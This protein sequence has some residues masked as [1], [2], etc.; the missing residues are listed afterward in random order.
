MNKLK[1]H[2]VNKICYDLSLFEQIVL[3]I[4]KIFSITGTIFSHSRSRAAAANFSQA[5]SN[6][7]PQKILTR[8]FLLDRIETQNLGKDQTLPAFPALAALRS[9][10]FW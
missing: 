7:L 1:K 3:V 9:G 6:I 10:Q 8:C 5:R 2:S 4:S